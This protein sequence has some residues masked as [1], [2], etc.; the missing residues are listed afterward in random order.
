[1]E[2]QLALEILLKYYK[3]NSY[4]NISI[5]HCFNQNELTR[6]QK[7]FITRVVY[8][9]VTYQL[10]LDYIIKQNITGRIK[11]YERVLMMMSLYQ[12]LFM[13]AIPNY[14][15]IN[16]A[17]NLAKH[18]GHRTASFINASLRKLSQAQISFDNLDDEQR[19]SIE[20]SHPLWL[21]KLLMKQYG[22]DT[23]ID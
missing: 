14:A 6:S 22:K 17:V 7:D 13:D 18:K 3:N 2:R 23:T 19:L 8:G 9:T 5:N 1:M 11:S 21:V 20:T 16:E 4:L 15:I 10:Y 12:I